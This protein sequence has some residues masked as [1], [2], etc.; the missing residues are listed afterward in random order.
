MSAPLSN[1]ISGCELLGLL[2]ILHDPEL[3]LGLID[4]VLPPGI[5]G[6]IF[7]QPFQLIL[8]LLKLYFHLVDL[9]IFGK[10]SCFG[11]DDDP[12]ADDLGETTAHS[13]VD[14]PI[15]SFD[16]HLTR[17]E[18]REEGRVAQEYTELSSASWGYDLDRLTAQHRLC[19]GYHV[20]LHIFFSHESSPLVCGQ[21]LRLLNYL[22]DGSD[23][24]ECLLRQIVHLT[25]NDH[26]ESPD[27]I[28]QLYVLPWHTS[29]LF[30]NTERL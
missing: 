19:R 21:L 25:G 7:M 15:L 6:I 29:E 23:H 10:V 8:G 2:P 26:L 3:Q 4:T 27:G 16:Y 1:H 18:G 9:D 24:V 20:K 5:F 12:V 22:F 14:V 17:L 30:R 28:F 13:H 11:E